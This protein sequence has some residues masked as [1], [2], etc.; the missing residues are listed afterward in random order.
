M[1][2]FSLLRHTV[3]VLFILFSVALLTGCTTPLLPTSGPEAESRWQARQPTLDA[4]R[5]WEF[6]GRIAVQREEEGWFAGLRWEQQ[7]TAYHLQVSGPAGQ[8]AARLEG[9]DTGVTLTRNNGAVYRALHPE[10]LL[11]AHLGWQV[12]VAGLHYWIRGLPSPL[13][14]ESRELDN[15]G[16]LIRLH[17]DGWDIHFERY[18]TV[19][20]FGSSNSLELPGRL[21]LE[22]PPLSVRIIVDHWRLLSNQSH[23]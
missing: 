16:H 10:E 3:S 9:D 23:H 21:V 13:A 2:A 20:S 8:G 6:N 14:W 22:R 4:L 11:V 17:Q 18:G 15:A 19:D 5:H 7:G 1:T 12:P